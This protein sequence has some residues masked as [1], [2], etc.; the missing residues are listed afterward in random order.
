MGTNWITLGHIATSITLSTLVMKMQLV[1][2]KQSFVVQ[3][4]LS[5]FTFRPKWGCHILGLIQA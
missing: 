4:R 1:L 3:M 2:V 5:S